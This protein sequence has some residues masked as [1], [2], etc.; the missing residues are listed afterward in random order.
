MFLH[1]CTVSAILLFSYLSQNLNKAVCITHSANILGNGMNSTI[2]PPVNSRAEWGLEPWYGNCFR[3]REVMN[4]TILPP[5]NSRAEWG[6]EPWYGN[7]FRRREVMNS[8]IL[9]PVNSRA[10]WGLEP[11][12]GNCFRRREVMNSNQL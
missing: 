9:P 10:E 12:Y 6:L 1:F 7:C 8:T 5:V 3:R 2:L 4:S 11:W